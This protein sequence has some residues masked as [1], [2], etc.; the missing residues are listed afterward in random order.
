M[1]ALFGGVTSSDSSVTVYATWAIAHGNFTC[2]YPH[3][4]TL[5]PPLYPLLSGALAALIRIGH[6][7][8]FPTVSQ[9][10]PHCSNAFTA[11][12]KWSN[13]AH[14]WRATLQLGDLSYLVLVAGV[15]T[16]LRTTNKS[17]RGWEPFTLLLIAL[18]PPVVM[19]FVEDFHPQDVLALGLA[20][21]AVAFARR[22]AWLWCGVFIGLALTSQQFALLV[23][24]PLFVI[25]SGSR[26][27]KFASSALGTWAIIGAP[28]LI[29][30]SGRSFRALLLGTGFSPSFGGTLLQETG[31]NLNLL[32]AIAR[33]V[34]IL[35]SLMLSVWALRRHNVSV[36][37]PSNLVSLIAT[38]LFLRLIFELNI[39]GYYFVSTSVLLIVLDVVQGRVRGT[40][41]AWLA[42]VT[43]VFNPVLLY[44]F[45]TGQTYNL[46]P[47]RAL[48]IIIIS[49]AL[50]IFIVEICRGRVHWYLVAWLALTIVAFVKSGWMYG[51]THSAFPTWFWQVVLF[52]S[53]IWLAAGPLFS[54]PIMVNDSLTVL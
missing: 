20:L 48:Q 42:L 33:V 15:V 47:F 45:A 8:A 31:L 54:R 2:A 23:A 40:T 10:G 38:S 25:A 35:A 46:G 51:P 16:L 30:T 6:S 19:P 44:A 21:V 17:R 3:A 18:A 1:S 39:W 49:I 24:V 28:F 13:K 5:A 7:V 43:L 50:L 29:V 22:E 41:I 32:T 14:A 9:L 4:N 34:P 36:L 11:I 37:L 26:R 12:G 52:S 53:G 27:L